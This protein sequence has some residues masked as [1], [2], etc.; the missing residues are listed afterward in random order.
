MRL[1]LLGNAGAGKSSLARQLQA[2]HPAERLSLDAVAFEPGS[3]QRRPLADS[4]AAVR[5]FIAAHE[6]WILEGWYADILAPVL[7]QAEE[8]IFLNPGVEVCAAHCRSR[9]FEP[10]KFTRRKSSSRTWRT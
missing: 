2:R 9:P 4:V 5:R 7:K 8:M 1:V 3:P 10:E 6:H